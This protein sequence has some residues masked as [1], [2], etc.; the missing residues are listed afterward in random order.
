MSPRT[1]AQLE[2]LRAERRES[3]LDAALHV[4][5]E[6]HFHSA[7]IGQL[8]KRAGIS[9]GLVYTYFKSKEDILVS[10]MIGM[11]DRLADEFGMEGS[12]EPTRE[13]MLHYVDVSFAV[14]QREPQYWRLFFGIIIQPEVVALV[15]DKMM[16]RATPYMTVV[17]SYFNRHGHENAMARMRYFSAVIDGIQLHLMLEGDA[18]PLEPV[19]QMLINEFLPE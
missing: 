19:K 18:F 14:V 17:S 1:T 2:V 11:F 13:L 8:A 10:L 16:E 9:K 15:L 12:P 6:E 7:S 4:F 3:I 5:A